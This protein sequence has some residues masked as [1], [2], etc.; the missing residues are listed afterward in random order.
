MKKVLALLCAAVLSVGMLAGCGS[1]SGSQGSGTSGS[2]DEQSGEGGKVVMLA[3]VPDVAE[4]Q[5]AWEEVA[6]AF[7]EETGIEVE[8]RFQGTWDEIPT[9]LQE[10]R[11]AGDQVDIVRVG[12]GTISS[13][14]G[15]A[16]G[17]KDLTELAAPLLDRYSEGMT[18]HC[19]IGD[20]LWALPYYDASSYMCLYNKTLFD[21]MGLQAPSTWDELL[22][23]SQALAGKDG[24]MPM[25]FQ[26][27]DGWAWPMMYTETYNQATGNDAIAAVESFL[28]GETSFVSDASVQAFDLVKKFYDD[29]VLTTASLDTDE[30]G[31]IATFAQGKAGMLFAGTWDY[32]T[33]KNSCDFEVGAFQ[34]PVMVEG[35]HAEN[36]YGVGDYALAIPSFAS[37]DNLEN[38]MRFLEYITRQENAQKILGTSTM[39]YEVLKGVS[40][41]PDEVTDFLNSQIAG[42]SAKYLD[43]I[44]P[45]EVNDALSTAIVASISGEMTSQEAAEYVQKA[46]D[47]VCEE[48]DYTYAWWES[49]TEEQ[50][51]NVTPSVIPDLSQ[52]M[53]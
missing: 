4:E 46:Y 34:F 11:L 44:W 31:M 53:K 2:S 35:S 17:V 50:W 14:L 12:I 49:W 18:D 26:G 42:N 1:S 45:S 43:W 23:V 20:H 27:K 7:Q 13:T 39:I 24:M 8:L 16:G 38:T 22:T 30:E 40:T 10:S 29:N 19:Y 15:A 32:E 48:Q 51:D 41:E 36:G 28:K 37:D 33:I 6:A 47:T 5:T 3:C 9:L 25:I 21:E 52:Y